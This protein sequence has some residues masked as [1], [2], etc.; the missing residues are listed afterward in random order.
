MFVPFL[1]IGAAAIVYRNPAGAESLLL[2]R[3]ATTP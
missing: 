1:E 3:I 2:T